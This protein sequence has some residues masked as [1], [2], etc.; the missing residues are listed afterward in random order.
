MKALANGKMQDVKKLK[1]D[2]NRCKE[3][4]SVNWENNGWSS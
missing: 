3:K 2:K 4:V 1:D